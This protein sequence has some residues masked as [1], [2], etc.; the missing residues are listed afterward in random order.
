MHGIETHPGVTGHSHRQLHLEQ[1][2]YPPNR[3]RKNTVR[4]GNA[5]LVKNCINFFCY[6]IR[7]LMKHCKAILHIR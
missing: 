3:V 1:S 7:W 2:I 5:T 6:G 4:V